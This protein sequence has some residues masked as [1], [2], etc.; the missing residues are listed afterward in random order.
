M[1]D[2]KIKSVQPAKEK[3]ENLLDEVKTMDL[4][5][6]YQHLSRLQQSKIKYRTISTEGASPNV[7]A[8]SKFATATLPT[9]NGDPKLWRGFWGSFDAALHLQKIPDIQRLSDLM[10]Q[11]KCSTSCQ[12]LWY[13]SR[14]K[15]HIVKDCRK[16]KKL[17]FHCKGRH[18]SALC[19][20]HRKD[21]RPEKLQEKLEPT[22]TNS[23]FVGKIDLKVLLRDIQN[24]RQQELSKYDQKRHKPTNLEISNERLAVFNF[25]S[26]LS[27]ISTNLAKRLHSRW[28]ED[29]RL[30]RIIGY[31]KQPEV[32]I[33]VKDFFKFIKLDVA[34]E[35]ESGLLLL[36]TKLGP[37]LAGNGYMDN[38]RKA[39]AAPAN[40]VVS[41]V[42]NATSHEDI[43]HFWKLE[44][45]SIQD[46]PNKNDD[47]QALERFKKS[48]TKQDRR[49]Q[50]CWP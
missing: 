42:A 2:T 49:Y 46:E 8:D 41:C 1:S 47:E 26:Q 3:L 31:W 28:V 25:G 29:E 36:R 39:S 22:V 16:L 35:L 44:L 37:M 9:F 21:T 12:R 23:I 20:N 32:L 14:K 10:P 34:Q 5:P 17:C 30:K 50:V 48:I 4:T 24:S 15:S 40:S 19:T 11:R 27:F 33:G 43:D 6:P 45:M 13:S 7:S 18:N 38:I